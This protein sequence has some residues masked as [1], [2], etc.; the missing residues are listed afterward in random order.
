MRSHVARTFLAAL[1][2]LLLTLSALGQQ[3]APTDESLIK[4]VRSNIQREIENAPALGAADEEIYRTTLTSLRRQLQK[5]LWKKTGALELRINNLKV[6]G[7]LPEVIAHADQLQQ[8]LDR[9]NGELQELDHALEGTV[10]SGPPPSSPQQPQQPQ[11][12]TVT[13]PV[14]T[15]AELKFESDVAGIT[16]DDLAGAAV[17][18]AV[19]ESPAPTCNQNGRPA[20]TKFSQYDEALCR[21]S[22]DVSEPD[23]RSIDLENDEQSLLTILI[24]KLLKSKTASGDSYASFVT[25]AQ[26]MRTDQQMGAGPTSNSATSIVSKGGIPYLLGFAVENG[27][28]Q[29]SQ[30]DTSITF[31]LNPGGL[32]NLLGKK[33]FITGF[34]ESG[35]DPLGFLSKTSVGLTFDT[36]RGTTPGVFTGTRQQLSQVS[37][38]FEFMNERD[39]RHKKYEAKWEKFVANEGV[40][41][42]D[43]TWKTTV[44]LTNWTGTGDITFTEPALQAWLNQTNAKLAGVDATLTGPARFNAIAEIVNEQANLVPVGLVPEKVIETLT[45]FARESKLYAKAKNDLLDEIAKGKIFTLEYTNKREVNAS[46][47]SNFNFIAATGAASRISLTSNGSFT[48]FHKRP[49]AASPTS[50]RPGRFRDFQFAGQVDVPFKVGDAQFDFWFSGRYERLLADATTIA[51]ATM[52]GTK[53]DIAVGQFGLNIPL[54]GLGMKFPVSFTFANRTELV[55]EKEV[56]GNFGFTFNWDTLFS[57]LKPF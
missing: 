17:P 15:T 44:L 24:A 28:A 7:A 40:K 5:L 3:A 45:D 55:K 39:P 14:K 43:Q 4:Q 13:P 10:A 32:I 16:R 8:E 9:I 31:R 18:A 42:A 56:R 37:A 23:V 11:T 33:G 26:E 49:L 48:F 19:A 46:D 50:S 52:P 57:K 12:R 54:P 51:G 2:A 34:Q 30:N 25:E 21:L 27:A 22:K 29:E 20:T 36:N 47:T 6:P 38:R 41:L 1:I 35:N 53:G